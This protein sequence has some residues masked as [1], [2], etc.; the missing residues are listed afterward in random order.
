MSLARRMAL[1]DWADRHDA[2]IVEDDYDSE[3]RYAGRP[4]EPLHSLDRYGRVVYVGSFTRHFAAWLEVVP[5]A[6]GL[7]LA[8][9]ARDP[10]VRIDD[11]V[12]AVAQRGVAVQ[13]LTMFAV[14]RP[15]RPGIVLGYGGVPLS[16]IP[17]GLRRLR[18]CVEE[19]S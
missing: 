2:A 11:I 15:T 1:L 17:E 5:S 16:R 14:D 19:A 4:V 7:H 3:F 13:S 6:A 9:L 18:R 8:A 10:A 12:A